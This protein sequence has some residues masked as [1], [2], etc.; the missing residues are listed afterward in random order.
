MDF[1]NASPFIFTFSGNVDATQFGLGS[2]VPVSFQFTYD[3]SQAPYGSSNA[4]YLMPITLTV[5][6]F[7]VQ[8]QGTVDVFVTPSFDSVQLGAANYVSV[9]SYGETLTGLINGFGVRLGTLDITN[10]VPPINM[11]SST[12]LPTSSAFINRANL[13]GLDIED[14]NSTR[15]I[16][17]S[18]GPGSFTL[19]VAPVAVPEPA[20]LLLCLIA[21]PAFALCRLRR[22]G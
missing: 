9:G 16:I 17:Q 4:T 2:S 21:I 20:T 1:G 11:L 6:G 8:E 18:Y 7:V 15:K 3:S 14:L 22:V 12:S 5:G 10:N 19:T 13:I